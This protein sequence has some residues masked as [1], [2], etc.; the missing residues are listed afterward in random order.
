M[1]D[2]PSELCAILEQAFHEF[3]SGINLLCERINA[4]SITQ[5]TNAMSLIGFGG[6]HLRGMLAVQCAPEFLQSSH[7]SV[8]MGMPVSDADI[9]DWLGEIA[10]QV[11]GRFK[12]LLL[13]YDV[14]LELSTPSVVSG[15]SLHVT[16]KQGTSLYTASF[17]VDGSPVCLQLTGSMI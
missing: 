10:N 9:E 2:F 15:K 14:K 8:A 7:P 4:D 17:Y 5:S 13:A 11:L 3:S 6:Q 1:L 16:T 12:N